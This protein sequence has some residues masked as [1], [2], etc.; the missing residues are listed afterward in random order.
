MLSM[1]LLSTT[2]TF[3]IEEKDNIL[4]EGLK[5]AALRGQHFYHLV[6]KGYR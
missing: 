2:I 1:W 4:A 3:S 6:C 5:A